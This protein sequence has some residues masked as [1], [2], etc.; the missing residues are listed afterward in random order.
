M[1][2]VTSHPSLSLSRPQGNGLA[3]IGNTCYLNSAIQA[4]RHA[5]P[6]AEYFKSSDWSAHAR[7]DRPGYNMATETATLV[8]ALCEKSS[9]SKL[10]VPGKFVKEFVTFAHDINEEIHYG[11]QADAA[12]AVHILL[13]GLHMQLS[14]EVNMAIRGKATSPETEEYIKSLESWSIFFNKEYSPLIQTFY[15]QTQTRVVCE[16]CSTTSSRYEPWNIL[17]LPI[18]GA[19]KPG[20]AAPTLRE[21]MVA[22]FATEKLDDYACDTCKSK[23]T[24]RMEHSLSKLPSHLILSL[25]RFTN[26][27]KKVRAKIPYD[28]TNIDIGDWLSWPSLKLPFSTQYRVYATI[29]HMGSSRGGHYIMRALEGTDWLIYD[30]ASV[31]HSPIGGAAGPDTYVLFLERIDI[32]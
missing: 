10:I 30:D 22:A 13:D 5:R 17:K 9:P 4:L 14:R 28:E 20:A 32:P 26:E 12:E 23:G 1:T 8:A 2:S 15:G 24:A 16:R 11:A 7:A 18:P 3:N 31:S 29:E 19:D 6:F 27:G 25:N 21:C